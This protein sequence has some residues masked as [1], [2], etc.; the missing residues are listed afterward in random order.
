MRFAPVSRSCLPSRVFDQLMSF[1]YSPLLLQHLFSLPTLAAGQALQPLSPHAFRLFGPSSTRRS[2]RFPARQWV[3][4][5]RTAQR[6]STNRSANAG[7]WPT[8]R[9]DAVAKRTLLVLRNILD[10]R[11]GTVLKPDRAEPG[12]PARR[13][14]IP[15]VST[16][17]GLSC[18]GAAIPICWLSNHLPR[19]A[20]M[21]ACCLLSCL[22]RAFVGWSNLRPQSPISWQRLPAGVFTGS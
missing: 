7:F 20:F 2:M 18:A 15:E 6:S 5:S 14:H 22:N 16:D 4:L 17:L 12:T 3:S 8:S 9:T 10:G 1:L 19:F 13:P 11:G 21:S